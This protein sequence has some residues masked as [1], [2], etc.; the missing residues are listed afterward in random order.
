MAETIRYI[1]A[2]TDAK[3]CLAISQVSNRTKLT[4]VVFVNV[5]VTK[6]ALSLI[7]SR[8]FSE[9]VFPDR[10]PKDYEIARG[11][12]N[13]E[14]G[15]IYRDKGV[16]SLKMMFPAGSSFRE[17]ALATY[18]EALQTV[19]QDKYGVTV[20]VSTHRPNSN[21][22]V[23]EKNGRELKFCGTVNNP[24]LNRCSS[25]I[26][27]HFAHE[28]VWGIYNLNHQKFLRRGAIT[29]INQVVAGLDQANPNI[30]EK[31][32]DEVCEV[33]AKK[34]GRPM[35]P[36]AFTPAEEAVIEK[37]YQEYS[38]PNWILNGIKKP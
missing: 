33:M 6:P 35:V 4:D 27:I 19:L 26:S 24:T 20:H 23:F 3:R 17:S 21:D 28:K 38:D 37:A 25:T 9:Y 30:T 12:S 36:G 32:L 16:H 34:L 10:I 13:V 31:L 15:V 11:V 14:S 22:M 2:K 7:S 18:Y 1:K 8:P 5:E 29:N